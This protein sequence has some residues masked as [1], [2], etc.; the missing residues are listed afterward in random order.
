MGRGVGERLGD[1]SATIHRK[2]STVYF[3]VIDRVATAGFALFDTPIGSCGIAWGH[4]GI[5]GVQLPQSSSAATRAR[6][7]KRFAPALEIEPP[8]AIQETIQDI[9]R[10]LHGENVDLS[11]VILDMSGVPGF[12]ARVYDV[13]RS[14]AAGGTI[15]Y[16]AIAER[17][18]MPT[19]ARAVGESLG[20]NPFPLIVPC[21]R[22][23]A[24]DGR[25]GGFSASGGVM[26]K[27]RLLSIEGVQAPGTIPLFESPA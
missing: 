8:E 13:A 18:G 1:S 5:T 6:M 16:G 9:V 21:H 4:R 17:L 27:L 3:S 24:A 12:S 26:T 7:L 10:L 19:E 11:R 14:V 20:K 25:P 23:L 22:V 15:S 2:P